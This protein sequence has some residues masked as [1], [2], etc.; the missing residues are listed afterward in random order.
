MTKNLLL[1]ATILLGLAVLGV[2]GYKLAP[3][4]S[5]KADIELALSACNLNQQSCTAALPD[6]GQLEFSIEPRPVPALK[7]LQLQATVSG[8][9]V[10]RVEVDFA[11]TEMKMGYNRPQLTSEPSNSQH[12]SGVASLPVCITGSME[13]DATVLVDTGKALVAVPFR[14]QTG[15]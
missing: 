15:N 1:D 6:G 2:I 8:G 5:P 13:W 12:F 7:P 9:E 10:R 3:L 14:F 11:G 4:L